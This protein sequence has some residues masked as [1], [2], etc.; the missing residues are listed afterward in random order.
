MPEGV[1]TA[2]RA[3]ERDS[4]RVNVFIDHTFAIGISLN[5]LAAEG[6][7]VGKVLDQA[8]WARLEASEHHE[9]AFQRALRFLQSRPRSTHELRQRLRRA[10]YPAA[11]IDAIVQRLTALGLL[12][13]AEFARLWIENRQAHRPRGTA[14]LRAEL[15]QKGLDRE[16]VETALAAA[17]DPTSDTAQAYVAAEAVLARYAAA[18]DWHTFERR[19]G[20]YLQ[21]RGFRFDT[22]RPVVRDLW[23]Q[24]QHDAPT[25]DTE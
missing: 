10:E 14:L 19:M 15:L 25:S 16:L 5:T 2:L 21:R 20:S 8:A 22:I 11:T 13:D 6:L 17:R 3:Q 24:I 1:I 9:R 23:Q 18:P 12:D 7:F 4:Q